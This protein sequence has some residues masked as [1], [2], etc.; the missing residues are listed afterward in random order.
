MDNWDREQRMVADAFQKGL[1]PFRQE[2]L[3]LY[4]IGRNTPAVLSLT[5]GFTFAGLLDQ[6]PENVGKTYYGKRVL[7]LEEAAAVSKRVIIIARSAFVP[8]IYQRI[9]GFAEKHGITVYNYAGQRQEEAGDT[10]DTSGLEYWKRSYDDL[11]AAIAAHNVVS[12]D[13]FDTL[14][15]R[16]VLQPKDIFSLVERDLAAIGRR[17]PYAKLRAEAE[18]ACGYGASLDDIYACLH[19]MGVSEEDCRDWRS[20]E[21]SWERAAVFPR[22]KMVEAL[23]YAKALGKHVF[24][25]SDMYLSENDMRMLLEHCGITGWDGLLIS[26]R[27]S[28]EKRDGTLFARL[29][30]RSG[31]G[32]VLHI[33]DD[34][35]RDGEMARKAG[36]DAWRI[37][38]GYDLL[39]VSS[40]RSLLAEPPK[41]LGD[42]LALGMMCAKLFEDPFALHETKG[43][44]VLSQAEQ[45]GYGFIGL[46]AL[47]FMQWAS[48]Q[49]KHHK[50]EEFLFPSRDGFLFFHMGQ[51]MR[52]Y[53][54]MPETALKYLKASR[55]ALQGASIETGEDLAAAAEGIT[56]YLTKGELLEKYFRVKPE[57]SD[58]ERLDSAAEKAPTLRYL[59]RYLPQ[60]KKRSAWERTNYQRYLESLDLYHGR[61]TAVF[62]FCAWGT[63]QYYLEKRLRKPM[64][65]LYC[66]RRLTQHDLIESPQIL[67]ACGSAYPAYHR[68]LS[69][70]LA[71]FWL[72]LE[73]LLVDGDRALLFF[74]ESGRAVFREDEGISYEQPLQIQAFAL[75]FAAEYLALFGREPISLDAAN[76]HLIA[77]F[78]QGCRIVQPVASAFIHDDTWELGSEKGKPILPVR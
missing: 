13:V 76:R 27:E 41:G 64:L 21:L 62:D 52:E 50:I 68:D 18:K 20:R 1:A 40:I 16:R 36:L 28:A 70:A 12:F 32:S 63:V 6:D 17:E 14:L 8:L 46:W 54:Y 78:G 29:L 45:I 67:S 47:S 4:G 53:G 60:I 44:V 57:S 10:Y 73:P 30:E 24:L 26:S 74:D 71:G 49:V 25:T 56:C 2:P 34:A 11:K 3:V 35:F 51:L 38:S 19:Q 69:N 59:N 43:R 58:P 31:G 72:A 75:S 7:S 33:G 61:R 66:S 65:G 55:S 48:V 22:R 23:Q 9:K 39:A 5:E 77:L 42:R 37:Y 15:G